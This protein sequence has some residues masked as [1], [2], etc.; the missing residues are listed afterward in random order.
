MDPLITR[1]TDDQ[2]EPATAAWWVDQDPLTGSI[3]TIGLSLIG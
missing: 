3:I 2:A 1:E